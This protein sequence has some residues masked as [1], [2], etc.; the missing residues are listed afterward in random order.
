LFDPATGSGAY[1]I[2]GGANGGFLFFLL[3]FVLLTLAIIFA[4]QAGSVILL[5]WE[6]F[7]FAS[8]VDELYRANTP[9][10]LS[11]AVVGVVLI[12]I[13]ALIPVFAAAG[14]AGAAVQWFGILIGTMLTN[15]FGWFY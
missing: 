11:R 7:S 6:I 15:P 3:G 5:M 13:L 12:A 4:L 2:T 9:Q 14:A 1:K 10:D 8:F